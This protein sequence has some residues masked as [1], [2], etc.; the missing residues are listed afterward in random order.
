MVKLPKGLTLTKSGDLGVEISLDDVGYFQLTVARVRDIVQND[1][2]VSGPGVDTRYMPTSREVET[3]LDMAKYA[4]NHGQLIDFGHWPND[5]I[6]DCGH[7]AGG[8]YADGALGHPFS[9]PYIILHSWEDAKLAP[10]LRGADR[11]STCAYLVNPFPDRNDP[12]NLCIDFEAMCFEGMILF[13]ERCMGIGDRAV[14]DG[15]ESRESRT[16]ACN[17]VPFAARWPSLL[18][19]DDFQK[20]AT[21]RNND[22]IYTAAA[23]NVMDPV[24]TA[25]LLLNT[26]GV[27]HTVVSAPERLNKARVKSGKPIIPAYRKVNSSNYVTAILNRV[28]R[29]RGPGTGTHASPV[30]HVRSGHWRTYQSGERSFIRDTLVNATPEQRERF[31]MGRSHYTFKPD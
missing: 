11:I 13:G 8:L 25:L 28:N 2:V 15:K 9:T 30:M 31:V 18:G 20:M 12:K 6:M 5:M 7:R 19:R 10:H 3:I 29:V 26:R 22:G 14:L 1:M 23:G 21:N 24:M 16:Y 27:E 17:V 4:V